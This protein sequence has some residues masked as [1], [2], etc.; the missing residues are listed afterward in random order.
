MAEEN[1][2]RRWSRRKHESAREE[3]RPEPAAS[4]ASAPAVQ[5]PATAAPAAPPEQVAELPPLESLKGLA[6][7]YKEFLDPAVEENL[8]RSALKKLFHDPHFNVMDGLD[9]Y[10]DD[11]SRPDPIP[12]SM[13]KKLVHA[14]RLLFPEE[15]AEPEE[16]PPAADPAPSAALPEPGAATAGPEP[17]TTARSEE[18][19]SR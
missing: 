2:L 12:E 16:P 5:P 7:D 10:I 4:P 1:F 18:T 3:V 19:K 9:V 11:Y 13:L 17:Q 15:Q 8:R 14:K 6:S